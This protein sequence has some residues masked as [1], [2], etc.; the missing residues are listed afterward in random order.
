ME[1]P[2]V[3]QDKAKESLHSIGERPH[4]KMVETLSV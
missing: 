4:G 2:L 1:L 3:M